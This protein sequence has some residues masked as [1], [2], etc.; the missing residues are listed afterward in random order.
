MTPLLM[1][2]RLYSQ[3]PQAEGDTTHA[4]FPAV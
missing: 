3:S 2:P 4:G 1:T